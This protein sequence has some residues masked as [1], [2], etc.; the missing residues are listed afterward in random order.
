ASLEY[1]EMLHYGAKTIPDGGYFSQPEL[2]H[3]GVMLI[4][5]TACML[6][7]MRLKGIHLAIESGMCAAEAI[8][9][10]LKAGDYSKQTLHRYQNL[11]E[12][13][14]AKREL[15]GVRNFR[16][17]FQHGQLIGMAN[18][19]FGIITG[20]FGLLGGRMKLKPDY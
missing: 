1:G 3:H 17:G 14:E 5:N 8:F 16:Q 10:A 4:G 2:T 18:T 6:N 15:W 9:H 11:Y 20:G 12:T 13:S 19:A 7:S